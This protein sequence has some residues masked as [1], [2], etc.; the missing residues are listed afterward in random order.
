MN[1]KIEGRRALVTGST[2]G[3]GVGIAQMLAGEGASVVVHGRSE[4]G[5][6][7][8]VE[9]ISSNQGTAAYV[10][11]DLSGTEDVRR[12]ATEAGS[13]FGGIDILV[14]CFGASPRFDSWF[15]TEPEAW[16]VRWQ[17]SLMYAVRLIHAFVPAMRDRGWGRVIN[18]SSASGFKPGAFAPEYAATKLALQ[19]I[20]VSL[21]QEL[22][23]SGVTANTVTCGL[24]F[25][26]NTNRVLTAHGR[27]LGFQ[28]TGAALERR[29]SAEVFN[30]PLRRAARVDEVGAAVV[31]LASDAASYITG[32]TLRVDGGVSGF[33]S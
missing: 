23:D 5:A 31:F 14:N 6:R 2:S 16:D 11:G 8:V 18:I 13:T 21:S 19:T 30:I 32:T 1:F 12:I 15:E 3:I 24:V 26:E 17:A 27:Q 10:L 7:A 28:E 29:L 20:A 22:L 4:A 9:K 25:T 33:V